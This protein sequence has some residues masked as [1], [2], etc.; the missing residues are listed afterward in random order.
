MEVDSGTVTGTEIVARID[1]TP[2]MDVNDVA[3]FE[4]RQEDQW[5]SGTES[6]QASQSLNT[7]ESDTL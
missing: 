7:Y 2:A 6:G 1:I 4:N 5:Q 3:L